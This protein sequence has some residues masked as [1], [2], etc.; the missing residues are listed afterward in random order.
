[1]VIPFRGRRGQW[2]PNTLI[3]SDEPI[4]A[5]ITTVSAFIAPLVVSTPT[6]L[7][8]SSFYRMNPVTLQPVFTSTSSLFSN[9][10]LIYSISL[11]V[12]QFLSIR[13]VDWLYDPIA[14]WN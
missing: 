9:F 10:S 5:H 7:Q 14:H 6:I 11:Y 4:P 13:L 2:M 3:K 8:L 12:L 1:M